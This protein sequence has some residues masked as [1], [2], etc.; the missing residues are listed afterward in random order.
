VKAVVSFP[1][2][3]LSYNTEKFW[4]RLSY[5]FDKWSKHFEKTY[6]RTIELTKNISRQAI[7]FWITDVQPEYFLLRLPP[8]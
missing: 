6:Q 4:D 5:T 1:E 8:M 2:G 3:M 7:P